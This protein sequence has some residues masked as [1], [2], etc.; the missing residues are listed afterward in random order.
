MLAA[1]LSDGANVTLQ[2][3]YQYAAV[4]ITNGHVNDAGEV[5]VWPSQDTLAQHRGVSARTV[6]THLKELEVLGAIRRDALAVREKPSEMWVRAIPHLLDLLMQNEDLRADAEQRFPDMTQGK[7]VSL[8]EFMCR[9]DLTDDDIEHSITRGKMTTGRNLALAAAVQRGTEKN[10]AAHTRA[11]VRRASR[12]EKAAPTPKARNIDTP[13]DLL[14]MLK[15]CVK[16]DL[17][18]I[19]QPKDTGENL[20]KMK[21]LADTF[22]YAA[23]RK[24]IEFTT[25]PANWN[26]LRVKFRIETPFPTP[27]MLLGFSEKW[28]PMA[29]GQ[30]VINPPQVEKRSGDARAVDLVELGVEKKRGRF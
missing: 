7:V 14:T 21:K 1:G 24:L 20:A 30:T 4:S 8:P 16:F 19:A 22:G 12:P 3:L 5:R 10:A 27:G 11:E 29:L 26:Q 28:V 15:S 18:S 13:H 17:E 23:T 9:R 25:T 6:G 2:V